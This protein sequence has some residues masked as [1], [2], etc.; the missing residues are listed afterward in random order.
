M[1]ISRGTTQTLSEDMRA[2]RLP[3]QGKRVIRGSTSASPAAVPSGRGD[4]RWIYGRHTVAAALANPERR[5]RRLAVLAGQE[6]EAQL[7]LAGAVA[8]RSGGA[9]G[10][11]DIFERDAF[12]ALL[13]G[14]AVHQGLALEVEPLREPEL[15][16]LLRELATAAGRCVIVALDQVSDPQNVGAVLRSAS[17]FG[18]RAVLLAT[19]GAPPVTGALAK[20]ASG[21]VDRVPLIRVNI[22]RGLM[23]LK[24]AGYW[25]CGLD[26]SANDPLAAL[27]L[28]PRAVLV[29]GSEGNG[30]RRLVRENCDFLARLPTSAV[31]SSLNVSSAAAVA[32]YELARRTETG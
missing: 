20:A 18:A 6:A 5:W 15:D 4:Q 26:E 11:L 8:E 2:N 7:L 13:A 22:V 17:A 19:H 30:M 10:S 21:A 28:G 1:P 29:L 3:H 27:D 12:A 31:Q 14:G 16:D 23:R 32:L 9:G 24:E 25:V